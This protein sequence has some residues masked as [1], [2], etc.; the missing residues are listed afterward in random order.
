MLDRD[1]KKPSA[2]GAESSKGLKDFLKKP[3]PATTEAA[4]EAAK[5][6]MSAAQAAAKKEAVT[7]K[8][9]QLADSCGCWG[10]DEG[11]GEDDEW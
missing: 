4:A 10:E 8:I 6:K 2:F 1:K 9:K 7:A 11:P 3:A 5:A